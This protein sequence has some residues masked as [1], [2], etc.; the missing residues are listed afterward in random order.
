MPSHPGSSFW[1]G[2]TGS[3]VG[4]GHGPIAR[5]MTHIY[6][7]IYQAHGSQHEDMASECLGSPLTIVVPNIFL[8]GLAKFP[9]A[10]M[11]VSIDKCAI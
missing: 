2:E 4:S 7:Y 11:V 6:I 5:K 1:V 3:L 9:P 10:T 8:S